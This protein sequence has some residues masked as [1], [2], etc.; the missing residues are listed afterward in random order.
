MNVC[1]CLCLLRGFGIGY[2]VPVPFTPSFCS[3]N[4][5]ASPRNFFN[6]GGMMFRRS[7]L[8]LLRLF[9]ANSV[10]VLMRQLFLEFLDLWP[11]NVPA[12]R[13]VLM[14]AIVVLMI[15]FGLVK[16]FQWHDLR[17]DRVAEMFLRLC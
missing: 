7:F 2:F 11:N 4:A 3:T 14:V 17:H 6:F 13:R 12:V 16:L 8:R 9:A 15:I 1:L 5:P 10:L